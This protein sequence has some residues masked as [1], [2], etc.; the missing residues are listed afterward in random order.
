LA[1][2]NELYFVTTAVQSSYTQNT[3][4][5]HQLDLVEWLLIPWC[6]YLTTL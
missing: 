5:N 3:L 6:L 4:Y 2:A 1:L